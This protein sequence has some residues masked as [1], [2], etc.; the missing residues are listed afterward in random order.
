[1]YSTVQYNIVQYSIVQY[2]TLEYSRVQYLN[3]SIMSSSG[4]HLTVPTE[5]ETEDRVVHHHEVILDIV[6]KEFRNTYH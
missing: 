2:I 1:M 4:Q 5:G 3:L 6:D